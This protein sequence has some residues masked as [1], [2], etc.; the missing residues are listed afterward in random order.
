[1]TTLAGSGS[2]AFADG[3]GTLASFNSPLGLAI[4]SNGIIYVADQGNSR[5]R[6]ISSVGECGCIVHGHI[7]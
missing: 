4:D 3:L 7:Y 2:V 6:S 5:L 1:M